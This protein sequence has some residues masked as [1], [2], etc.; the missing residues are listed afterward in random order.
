MRHSSANALRVGFSALDGLMGHVVPMEAEQWQLLT[1]F[2]AG[3]GS[4]VLQSIVSDPKPALV[5]V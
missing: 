1:I 3:F 2:V 5:S 4:S